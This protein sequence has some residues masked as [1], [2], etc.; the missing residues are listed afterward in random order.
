M[1]VSYDGVLAAEGDIPL[2][3]CRSL[4]R[5]VLRGRITAKNGSIML[6]SAGSMPGCR[7]WYCPFCGAEAQMASAGNEMKP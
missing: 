2:P 6:A 4:D 3:C 1:S 5:E 7:I